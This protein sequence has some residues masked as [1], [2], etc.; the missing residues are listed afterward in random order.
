MWWNFVKRLGSYICSIG[1]EPR[2]RPGGTWWRKTQIIRA[3]GFEVGSFVSLSGTDAITAAVMEVWL[4]SIY[5]W[6][7]HHHADCRIWNHRSLAWYP[8]EKWCGNLFSTANRNSFL[9]FLYYRY[10]NQLVWHQ[11]WACRVKGSY[12]SYK[13]K[14]LIRFTVWKPNHQLTEIKL[15]RIRNR[16]TVCYFTSYYYYPNVFKIRILITSITKILLLSFGP[17]HTKLLLT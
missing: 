14:D 4:R 16:F 7:E 6:Y 13:F 11:I 9:L 12:G 5:S 17:D 15:W 3:V 8:F 1:T 10:C 2:W